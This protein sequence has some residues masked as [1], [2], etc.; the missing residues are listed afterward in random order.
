MRDKAPGLQLTIGANSGETFL[1]LCNMLS[2]FFLKQK[3]PTELLV[4]WLGSIQ[5][6][7]GYCSEEEGHEKNHVHMRGCYLFTQN[8]QPHPE[9][10]DQGAEPSLWKSCS[11]TRELGHSQPTICSLPT[12]TDN[13]FRV[14]LKAVFTGTIL[15]YLISIHYSCPDNCVKQTCTLLEARM[16]EIVN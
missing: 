1:N 3:V 10:S 11:V 4:Q 15:P 5:L 9:R 6:M 2:V 7:L 14:P 8:R 16:K 12:R 13:H